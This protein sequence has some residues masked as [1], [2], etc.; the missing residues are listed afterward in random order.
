M[1][2]GEIKTFAETKCPTCGHDGTHG[3]GGAHAISRIWD[4]SQWL[5]LDSW[6]G[7]SLVMELASQPID[8]VAN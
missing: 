6:A 1:V 3:M 5:L 2:K 7:K 8:S 4:G